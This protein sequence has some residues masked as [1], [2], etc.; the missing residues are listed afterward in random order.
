MSRPGEGGAGTW[1]DGKLTT[2]IGRNARDVRAVLRTL[3][4]HGAPR[5]ILSQGSPHLG[6]DGLIGILK[7][8]RNRLVDTGVDV[9]FAT[10]LLGF[11]TDEGRCVGA[12]LPSFWR[13]VR[14]SV[15]GARVF[16]EERGEETLR[17]D[18]VV[19]ATGHSADDVYSALADCGAALEAK[20]IAVGFR[21]EHPSFLLPRPSSLSDR[22][23]NDARLDS[24][25]ALI[26][27][28]AYSD[29][30]SRVRTGT[31]RT[32]TANAAVCGDDVATD[33]ALP[34]AAY[35]LAADD[36]PRRR[37]S[38][39]SRLPGGALSTDVCRP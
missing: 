26:N 19:V 34:V 5:E 10:R 28:I 36:V 9:R 29:L 2:R 39:L 27:K 12:C 20:A 18:A 15:A 11:E 25:Q 8:T 35:R 6:T 38:S 13:G 1:S 21:V 31:R 4:A 7:S 32:D 17:A 33:P 23:A 22:P 30:A 37:R 3:V 24:R 16:N 14:S